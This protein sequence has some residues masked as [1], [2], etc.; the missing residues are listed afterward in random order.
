[1]ADA[2]RVVAMD[3][4]TGKNATTNILSGKTPYH[5]Q[6]MA[7]GPNGHLYIADYPKQ[8]EEFDGTGK[9]VTA[10]QPS[11]PPSHIFVDQNGK[12]YWRD[13]NLTINR[14]DDM[15]GANKKTLGGTDTLH[16]ANPAGIATDT[17]GFV[18]IAEA[19]GNYIM[20]FDPDMNPSSMKTF[21]HYGGGPGQF[22]MHDPSTFEAPG[23]AIAIDQQNKVYVADFN[24]RRVVRFDA[25]ALNNPDNAKVATIPMET[26]RSTT[27]ILSRPLGVTVDKANPPHIYI[28]T[29]EQP[30]RSKAVTSTFL[31]Q[32]YNFAIPGYDADPI[33]TRYGG[34]QAPP[35][36]QLGH[37]HDPEAVAVK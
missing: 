31:I 11:S 13:D 3:D 30:D 22:D 12:I 29:E 36:G 27:G 32:V 5:I 28:T 4:M 21:G 6:D 2:T 15:T 35:T 24:N 20:R 19:Q 14:I 25:D 17:A 1:M 16:F 37:F 9:F 26:L 7:F 10:Y 8:I 34:T 33:V 23:H 18:Y